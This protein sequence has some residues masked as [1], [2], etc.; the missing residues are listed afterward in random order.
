MCSKD[1]E[2]QYHHIC[3]E[4]EIIIPL[5]RSC[6]CKVHNHGTG[7]A[8]SSEDKPDIFFVSNP[9]PFIEV[10]IDSK[11]VRCYRRIPPSLLMPSIK[12]GLV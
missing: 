6:H 1:K 8:S 5:C 7:K 9:N 12:E 2:I 10:V 3:Y 4:P 11:G